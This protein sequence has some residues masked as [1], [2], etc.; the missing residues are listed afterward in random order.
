MSNK[1]ALLDWLM[2][3]VKNKVISEAKA[4]KL[5]KEKYASKGLN[6]F[7]SQLYDMV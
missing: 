7:L 5:Y 3:G 1:S 6:E 4:H 2:I